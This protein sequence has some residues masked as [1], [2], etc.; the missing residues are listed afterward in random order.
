MASD[1]LFGVAV[2]ALL[3]GLGAAAVNVSLPSNPASSTSDLVNVLTPVGQ[4][5]LAGFLLVAALASVRTVGD[6]F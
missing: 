1:R 4:L 6:A 3:A 2:M 5:V